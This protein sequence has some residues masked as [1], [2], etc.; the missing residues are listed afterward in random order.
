MD[1]PDGD[2]FRQQAE[3]CRWLAKSV[4]TKEAKAT[5]LEMAREYDQRADKMDEA[6]K[7]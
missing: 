1:Q 4:S 7:S 5:L 2:F 3:K 6:A